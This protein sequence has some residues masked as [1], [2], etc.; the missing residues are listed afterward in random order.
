MHMLL[1][2][3]PM[4][5]VACFAVGLL[6][7]F[8]Q[9]VVPCLAQAS[10]EQ[11]DAGILNANGPG[12]A[13]APDPG[14]VDNAPT[15]EAPTKASGQGTAAASSD[16]HADL[17]IYLWFPGMHGT[18]GSGDYTASVHASAGDILSH[19]RFGLMGTADFRYKRFVM[20]VDMMWVRL[21]DDNAAPPNE[22]G[23]SSADVKIDEFLLTPYFGYRAIDQPMVKFDAV[24][25][26]RYWHL[27][28]D[29][30]LYGVDGGTLSYSPSQN[31]ADALAGGRI[32]LALS[33][34]MEVTMA[35]DVGGGGS[36]LD[37]Q[38]V[39][40]LGYRIKPKLMLQL[41]WRYLS[42]NYRSNGVIFDTISSGVV[43][44][45]TIGLK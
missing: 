7:C 28:Q 8:S 38:A 22:E 17:L 14:G 43:L 16:L 29:L 31:W 23:L 30:Q 4:L 20:P 15:G 40:A 2:K 21:R 24:A 12:S 33:P 6:I 36:Q 11:N 44:G 42:V 32:I 10:S 5:T 35:G 26:V 27:G 3:K 13:T 37:Y 9:A 18:V 34:K 45:L 41:G 25:G 19:F 39:G 1:T